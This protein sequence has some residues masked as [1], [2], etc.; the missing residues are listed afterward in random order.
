MKKLALLFAICILGFNLNGQTELDSFYKVWQDQSQT[1]STRVMAYKNYI[2]DGYLFSNPDSAFLLAEQMHAFGEDNNY[3]IAVNQAN[4]LKSIAYSIQG[5][6]SL[7][8]DYIQKS[9]VAN[10]EIDNKWGISESHIVLGVIYDEQGNYPRALEHYNKALSIDEEIGNK[11]GIAMS[12]NN[13]GNIYYIQGNYQGALEKY[14]K[15]LLIDRELGVK[16]GIAAALTNIGDIKGIMN[17]EDDEADAFEY[18][19]EALLIYE[20]LRDK[21]GIAHI[22]GRIASYYLNQGNHLRTLE[23]YDQSLGVY[24]ELGSRLGISRMKSNIGRYHLQH[25]QPMLAE[26]YCLNSLAL[27]EELGALQP[28]HSALRCLYLFYKEMGDSRR[29]LQYHEQMFIVRDSIYNDENTRELTRIQMQY[30]FDRKEAVERA[31]Q[32]KRD[33]IA[34]QQLQRQ[35]LIRNGFMGGFSVVLLFAGVFFIQRNRI[36]KEKERS[37]NL[38]LNILPEETAKELKEKGHSEAQFIEQVT[39]IFTDFKGFT[40]LSEQLTPRALVKDLHDCFS[41]FD[42]ICDKYGI[43]KIKTIGDSYMAAGGLPKPNSTHPNDVVK[44]ALEMREFVEMGKQKKLK[45]GLPFFE[46]RLG[47]HTGPVVAGIVG[48]KKFQYDI[49]GD[50]VNTASRMES[51]GE[52]GR[53]NI[54]HSTFELIKDNPTFKFEPRGKVEV[55]GKGKLRMHFVNWN[56]DKV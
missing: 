52:I 36:G 45:N 17:G 56:A 11:V 19:Q 44:A 37:E 28:Q 41:A 33:A 22:Y 30:E 39:V 43:E 23:Y 6:P 2:W 9:L 32:E 18:F 31:E 15:S 40:A 48:V 14:E 21:E 12:L 54:S 20:E 50:T 7:A 4:T 49:W 35:K 47:I 38:L 1:D 42:H 5:E 26:E 27:A 29:A 24:K 3:P 8:R 46:I 34:A 51:N 25:G 16:Q 13:I 55:K 53:V 10:M